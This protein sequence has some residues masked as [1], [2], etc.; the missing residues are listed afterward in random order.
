MSAAPKDDSPQAIGSVVTYLR[1]YALQSMVGVAPEDDDG[2]AAQGRAVVKQAQK[3]A[4]PKGFDDWLTD[5]T[6][7]ADEGTAKLQKTWTASKV[8]YRQFLTTH[9]A[10]NWDAL[11]GIAAKA[12]H[13]EEQPA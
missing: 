13:R 1:R 11:K 3:L 12:N 7:V 2:E 6:A 8:E 10:A 5:L 9:Y 4:A